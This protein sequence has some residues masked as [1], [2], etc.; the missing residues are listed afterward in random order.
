MYVKYIHDNM[1]F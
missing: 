1:I